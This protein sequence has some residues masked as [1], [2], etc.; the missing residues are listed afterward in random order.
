VCPPIHPQA[1]HPSPATAYPGKRAQAAGAAE[2]FGQS[3]ALT[4]RLRHI[5]HDYAMGPGVLLEL[6]QVGLGLGLG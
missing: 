6:L 2:A 5:I 4:T 1:C 3:E